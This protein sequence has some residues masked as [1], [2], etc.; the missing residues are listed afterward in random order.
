M[1]RNSLFNA[2]QS[3][4]ETILLMCISLKATDQARHFGVIINK[5]NY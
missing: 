4:F 3:E 2:F 1:I 5:I